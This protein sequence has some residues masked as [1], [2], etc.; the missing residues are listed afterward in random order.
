MDYNE[1]IESTMKHIRHYIMT[2]HVRCEYCGTY[3]S[4]TW[5]GICAHCPDREIRKALDNAE[6]RALSAR[7][8]ARGAA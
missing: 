4:R 6:L 3:V 1:L 8:Q 5:G 7:I 2:S